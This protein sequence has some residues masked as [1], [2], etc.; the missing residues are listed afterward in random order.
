[1][2]HDFASQNHARM[3]RIRVAASQRYPSL[4]SGPR[5][6]PSFHSGNP[7][8]IV[9]YLISFYITVIASRQK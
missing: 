7:V 5:G 9:T 2:Y 8:A 3:L 4:R 6:P 1:M